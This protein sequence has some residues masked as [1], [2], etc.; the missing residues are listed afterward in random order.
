MWEVFVWEVEGKG[1][2]VFLIYKM[3]NWLCM[4]VQ[5][6]ESN[7]SNLLVCW[8]DAGRDANWQSYGYVVKV[9]SGKGNNPWRE[10]DAAGC[11]MFQSLWSPQETL[12]QPA[13]TINRLDILEMRY[14]LRNEDLV[15]P[16]A[17]A[18]C[19]AVCCII[20]GFLKFFSGSSS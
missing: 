10:H 3:S 17:Y 7:Y 20:Y 8:F 15:L 5:L 16:V 18:F 14:M 11:S 9:R 2:A 19:T 6:Y 13:G 12:G 1:I 4:E